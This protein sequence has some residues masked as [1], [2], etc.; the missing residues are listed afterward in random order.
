MNFPK[1]HP[2]LKDEQ[3][4]KLSFRYAVVLNG[5]IQCVNRTGGVYLKASNYID[6]KYLPIVERK[7]FNGEIL[8]QMHLADEIEFKER[9][10]VLKFGSQSS[11]EGQSTK[12]FEY[13]G[14]LDE[15]GQILLYDDLLEDFDEFSGD[16]FEGLDNI[17]KMIL[18]DGAPDVKKMQKRNTHFRGAMFDPSLMMA[19][20]D[21]FS[22]K[23]EERIISME[24]LHADLTK[25]KVERP[26]A[27]IIMS[28]VSGKNPLYEDIAFMMPYLPSNKK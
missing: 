12:R 16:S 6:E 21:V 2:L 24:F 1:L 10:I 11:V 20:V 26:S 5:F 18:T 13:S 15:K 8:E 23:K 14:Q 17:L 22:F 27:P 4:G 7:A 9:E 28:P 25:D 3:V 19:Y